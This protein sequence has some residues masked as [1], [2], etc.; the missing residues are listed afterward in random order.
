MRIFC[1]PLLV[2]YFNEL[3][4]SYIRGD[5]IL[6]MRQQNYSKWVPK[7]IRI[8][9]MHLNWAKTAAYN[10]S[11]TILRAKNHI[12]PKQMVSPLW[13]V[14]CFQDCWESDDWLLCQIWPHPKPQASRFCL[15]SPQPLQDFGIAVLDTLQRRPVWAQLQWNK[16][17]KWREGMNYPLIEMHFELFTSIFQLM[18]PPILTFILYWSRNHWSKNN[19]YWS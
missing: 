8:Y 10:V 15:F 6:R 18:L 2:H 13:R 17:R 12:P 16:E 7:C 14:H 19:S 4:K 1:T 3:K 9:K 11:L 5:C